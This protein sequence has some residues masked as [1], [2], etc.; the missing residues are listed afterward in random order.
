M[1][2]HPNTMRFAWDDDVLRSAR[3]LIAV[4]LLAI[5]ILTGAPVLMHH[6]QNLTPTAAE[7][8]PT[9]PSPPGAGFAAPA[10]RKLPAGLGDG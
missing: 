8:L 6:A 4:L 9:S 10:P 7:E 2:P 1:L 5:M 3:I